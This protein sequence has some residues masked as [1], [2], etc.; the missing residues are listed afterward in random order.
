MHK[1]NRFA[2]RYPLS[3]M[4]EVTGRGGAQMRVQITDISASGCRFLSKG[5]LSVGTEVTVRIRTGNDEFQASAIVV[6]STRTDTGVMFNRVNAA[7]LSLLEKW[8]IA[9]RSVVATIT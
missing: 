9:A 7:S 4:A 3:V 2:P 1:D 5:R 6:R 8:L